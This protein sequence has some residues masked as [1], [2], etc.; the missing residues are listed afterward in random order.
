MRNL[1]TKE[2]KRKEAEETLFNLSKKFQE[3]NDQFTVI[4][5]FDNTSLS[6]FESE[7]LCLHSAQTEKKMSTDDWFVEIASNTDDCERIYVTSDRELTER[8]QKCNVQVVKPSFWFKELSKCLG[9]EEEDLENY[10]KFIDN[11][12][13]KK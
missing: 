8:L 3:S 10:Q 4:L 11:Y 7:K 5:I 2:R 9:Q 12:L 13:Q 6:K 1:C